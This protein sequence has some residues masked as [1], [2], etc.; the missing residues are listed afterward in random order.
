M[1]IFR[2]KYALKDYTNYYKN[3]KLEYPKHMRHISTLLLI[4]VGTTTLHAAER[5]VQFRN[6]CTEPVWLG[7][8]GGSVNRRGGQDTSCGADG[9]CIQGTHCIVTGLNKQCFWDNPVPEGGDY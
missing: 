9:D 7:F 4:L 1:I 5:L 3:P 6:L 8:A 2:Y